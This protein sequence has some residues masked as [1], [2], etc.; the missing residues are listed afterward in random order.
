MEALYREKGGESECFNADDRVE[1]TAADL[2]NLSNAVTSGDLP[3]TT[4]F[5]Y[6]ESDGSEKADDLDFIAKAKV[7]LKTGRKV[8]YSSWW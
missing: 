6:G 3:G 5:F 7:L 1:L 8:Y 4:G 2:E